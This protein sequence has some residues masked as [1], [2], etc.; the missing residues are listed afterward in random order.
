MRGFLIAMVASVLAAP[1]LAQDLAPGDLERGQAL[2]AKCRACHTYEKGG[3]N[4]V[5]PRLYGMFGRPSGAVADYRYSPALMAA[6]LTWTD[7]VLDR[8]LAATQEV[9]P[10][11]KMYGGLAIAQDRVDLIAWLKKA[12]AE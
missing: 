3:R 5:G 7:E 12:T 4:L 8:Y 2:W 9:V 1:G 6:N 10:G 11:G